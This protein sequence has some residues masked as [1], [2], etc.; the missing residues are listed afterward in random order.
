LLGHFYGKD[1]NLYQGYWLQIVNLGHY[2]KYYIKIK[3][4]QGHVISKGQQKHSTFHINTN[5][6]ILIEER[7]LALVK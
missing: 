5:Y 1:Y 3:A 6:C 2:F 7:L 4:Y